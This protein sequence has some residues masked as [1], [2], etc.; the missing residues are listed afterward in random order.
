MK[1]WQ[2]KSY[3]TDSRTTLIEIGSK[4]VIENSRINVN[5]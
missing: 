2:S 3:S 5:Y 1:Q 4:Y